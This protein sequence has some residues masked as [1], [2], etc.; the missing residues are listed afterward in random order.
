M[1]SAISA[2]PERGHAVLPARHLA[3]QHVQESSEE[4]NHRAIEE[5]ADGEAC[6]GAKIHDQSQKRQEIRIDSGG[7]DCAHD[8]V[9]Q[10]LAA[11][12]NCPG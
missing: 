4:N 8:F 3:V 12:S 9:Q 6:R 2:C 10:P 5:L 11:G 7:R 1:Y